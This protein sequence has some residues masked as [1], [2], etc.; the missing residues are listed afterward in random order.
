MK[1]SCRCNGFTLIELTFVL[2]IVAILTSLALP[3]YQNVVRKTRRT[4]AQAA[5]LELALKQERWRSDHPTYAQVPAE[6]GSMALHGRLGRYYR[7]EIVGVTPTSFTVQAAAVA[8]TGQDV[9]RQGGVVCTPLRID[10]SGRRLP[11]DCW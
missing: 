4:E 8:G 11:V 10:Q 6:I 9:D 7:F 3:S 5:L 2:A 1:V